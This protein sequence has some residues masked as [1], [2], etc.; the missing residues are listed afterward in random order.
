MWP[1]DCAGRAVPLGY[2]HMMANSRVGL[3][4]GGGGVGGGAFHAGALAALEEFVDWDARRAA[5]IVGN[6][7]ARMFGANWRRFSR[8]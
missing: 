5:L 6:S 4:L 2:R 7:N 1:I 3:V 8:A